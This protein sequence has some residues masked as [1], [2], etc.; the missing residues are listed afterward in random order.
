MLTIR[1]EQTEA[2]RQ[3]HLQKFEDE[4][5]AHLA[6]FAPKH[7]QILGVPTGRRVIQLGIEQAKQYGFTNR[8]PVRFYLELMFMFGSYFDTDPQYPWARAVLKN[9][10]TIDQMVRA[11]R[12]FDAM[13]EYVALVPGPKHKYFLEALQRLTNTDPE[14]VAKPGVLLEESALQRLAVIYPQT[15]AYLG[16]SRI[17][18]M[19]QRSLAIARKYEFTT[20][21]GQLLM[22]ALMFFM[23]H[24]FTNDP[25]CGWIARRLDP[26]HRSDPAARTEELYAKATLYMKS[27]LAEN[28]EA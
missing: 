6:K 19:V 27:V 21:K 14:N 17:R 10:E 3:H 15:V 4:M 2:F 25:L 8:G 12:L 26:K 20:V 28:V 7:W 5:V 13:N 1:Q 22:V 18:P 23:G 9:P 16:E 24:G 11:D